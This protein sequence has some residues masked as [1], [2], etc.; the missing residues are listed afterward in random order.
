MARLVSL[1]LFY[2]LPIKLRRQR[3]K[4]HAL[5]MQGIAI[6]MSNNAMYKRIIII[7]ERTK[8]YMIAREFPDDHVKS[9]VF[10]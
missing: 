6:L 10:E 5:T 7:A 9:K 4:M 3:N 1:V 2:I 8:L